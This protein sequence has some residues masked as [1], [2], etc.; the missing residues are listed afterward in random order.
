MEFRELEQFFHLGRVPINCQEDGFL[1]LEMRM[2]MDF[3]EQWFG[4]ENQYGG[5]CTSNCSCLAYGFH[6]NVGCIPVGFLDR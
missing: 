5:R 2:F 3:V 4:L 1:K 6:P